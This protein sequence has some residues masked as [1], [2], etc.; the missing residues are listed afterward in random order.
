MFLNALLTALAVIGPAAA[1]FLAFAVITAKRSLAR[2][3]ILG[4][5]CA[6]IVILCLA[7]MIL[8]IEYRSDAQYLGT[9]I[10]VIAIWSAGLVAGTKAGMYVS[11]KGV[12]K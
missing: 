4:F 1:M 2:V 8:G 6:V 11:N 7:A 3:L 5:I 9:W 12:G 10:G